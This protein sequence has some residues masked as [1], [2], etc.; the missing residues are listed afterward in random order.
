MNAF[1]QS[2]M[3]GEDKVAGIQGIGVLFPLVTLEK[4]D[5]IKSKDPLR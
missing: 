2:V 5:I 1:S 4:H 3:Q